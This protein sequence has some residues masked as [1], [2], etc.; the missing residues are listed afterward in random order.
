MIVVKLAIPEDV[1]LWRILAFDGKS[2]TRVVFS[3]YKP[4]TRFAG[5]THTYYQTTLSDN[6]LGVSLYCN[7]Y[8]TDISYIHHINHCKYVDTCT[9]GFLHTITIRVNRVI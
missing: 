2:T 8:E 9:Y 1:C 4:I 3:R 6:I 7:L 5:A